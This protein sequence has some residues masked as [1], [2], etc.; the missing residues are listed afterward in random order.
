VVPS[1]GQKAVRAIRGS[2][3]ASYNL[4]RPRSLGRPFRP[5]KLFKI[6]F[7]P[8]VTVF[9]KKPT[10]PLAPFGV[11]FLKGLRTKPPEGDYTMW[12]P[13]SD[14]PDSGTSACV[15]WI[16]RSI[17]ALDRFESYV[18]GAFRFSLG[19]QPGP[20]RNPIPEQGVTYFL[21]G[22]EER[23]VLV[24]VDPE[25]GFGLFF[26]PEQTPPSYRDDLWRRFAQYAEASRALIETQR[27][28]KDP[29]PRGHSTALEHWEGVRRSLAMHGRE[30][31]S[32]GVLRLR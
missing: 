24:N 17:R 1:F 16:D 31:A 30:V 14:D 25:K 8:S 10:N 20:E 15:I 6:D 23:P 19:L 22:P 32:L 4:Q 28:P 21:E 7:V 29:K 18:L 2:L 11:G 3:R 12:W 9:H 27:I 26:H 13:T 5:E